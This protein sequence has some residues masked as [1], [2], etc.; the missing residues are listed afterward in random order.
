M[1]QKQYDVLSKDDKAKLGKILFNDLIIGFLVVF[2]YMVMFGAITFTCALSK[3]A[4]HLNAF[5]HI[6]LT[7]T[8]AVSFWIFFKSHMNDRR[9]ALAS[10]VMAIVDPKN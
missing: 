8:S 4:L 9:K 6:A 2:Q 3:Q 5:S 7:A 10:K 1:N